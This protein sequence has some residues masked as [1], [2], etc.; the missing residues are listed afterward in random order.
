MIAVNAAMIN[1]FSIPSVT[2]VRVD[3]SPANPVNVAAI[4]PTATA[5]PI[6]TAP[7]QPNPNILLDPVLGLVVIQF[8]DNA[9]AITTSIPSA[10]QLLEYQRWAATQFGPVPDGM[11][12]PAKPHTAPAPPQKPAPAVHKSFM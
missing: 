3:L 12:V 5:K 11:V 10:R 1:E 8:R 7:S 4:D 6:A 9:G 2:A